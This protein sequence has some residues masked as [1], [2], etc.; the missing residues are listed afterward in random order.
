M[1]SLGFIEE[2]I[3]SAVREDTVL[4]LLPNVWA[5]DCHRVDVYLS[6]FL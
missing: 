2:A 6:T 1:Y 5:S 4:L 3:L